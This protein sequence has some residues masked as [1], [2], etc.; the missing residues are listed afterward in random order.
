MKTAKEILKGQQGLFEEKAKYVTKEFQDYGYRLALR[1]NDLS[2]KSLYIKLAKEENR[3]LLENALSFALDYPKAKSKPKI[4]MWKLKEL[5][6]K[7]EKPA[8]PGK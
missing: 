2:H 1:L 8:K 4:F 5:K 6:E 3:T 7:H